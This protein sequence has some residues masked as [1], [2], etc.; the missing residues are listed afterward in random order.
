MVFVRFHSKR[1]NF[2]NDCR[3]WYVS[4]ACVCLA[5][6]SLSLPLFMWVVDWLSKVNCFVKSCASQPGE[7]FSMVLKTFFFL[8]KK[9]CYW[10]KKAK[11]CPFTASL[12]STLEVPIISFCGILL[13]R[14]L[15]KIGFPRFLCK[16]VR[17]IL[18]QLRV[19]PNTEF[20]L[21]YGIVFWFQLG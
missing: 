11:C 18:Y 12:L 5:Q 6:L 16:C 19:L 15:C 8:I 4:V 17:L 13:W 20:C 10:K 21:C 1:L 14:C 2:S 7:I 9:R 3:F